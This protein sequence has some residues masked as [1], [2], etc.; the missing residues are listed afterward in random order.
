MKTNLSFGTALL[1][2]AVFFLHPLA[3]CAIGVQ[4]ESARAH[5][6]CQRNTAPEKRGS[7]AP[8]CKIPSLPASQ[9]VFELAGMPAIPELS[10]TG[11]FIAEPRSEEATPQVVL[12]A[13]PPF[14]IH[15]H[16]LLI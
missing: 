1:L 11:V 12:F 16:Q 6:C 10:P 2:A 7:E 13:P 14:F 4:A 9:G 5:A 3:L 15:F 8:C